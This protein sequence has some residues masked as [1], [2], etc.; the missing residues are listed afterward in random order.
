MKGY[1]VARKAG[2]D[3]HGL[4]VELEVEKLLGIDGKPEIE[5]RT[6]RNNLM[7]F[8]YQSFVGDS[9]NS[10]PYRL[11]IIV[12]VRDIG[13]VHIH[14]IADSVGHSLPFALVFPV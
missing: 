3:T 1:Y 10:P 11:N 2:W 4:P 14:P 5:S 13:V 12:V 6:V 9:L 7:T 8:V